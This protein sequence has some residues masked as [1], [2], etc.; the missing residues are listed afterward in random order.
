MQRGAVA[1][2]TMEVSEVYFLSTHAKRIKPT[3]LIIV[4]LI[5]PED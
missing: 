2:S 1:G 3:G 4:E 5:E